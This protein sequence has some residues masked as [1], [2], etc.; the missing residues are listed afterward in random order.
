MD[1]FILCYFSGTAS[2]VNDFKLISPEIKMLLEDF[3]DMKLLIVG[4]MEFPAYMNQLINEGKIIYK[5]LVDFLELQR[6]IAEVDVNIVP[7]IENTF[8]NCKSELKFFE[9]C[10]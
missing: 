2:H 1:T 4:F 7:L 10:I 9:A 6:L 5:S 8:T 3:K